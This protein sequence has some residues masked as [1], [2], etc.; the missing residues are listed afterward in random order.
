MSNPA[1]TKRPADDVHPM[2][3]AAERDHDALARIEA[4]QARIE[5]K[6]DRLL[7]G[8]RP[9][10]LSR[11]DRG[12]CELIA[13][14]EPMLRAAAIVVRA[15]GSTLTCLDKT[16]QV[17]FVQTRPEA[18]FIL[19]TAATLKGLYAELGLS[20]SGRCRVSL[21]PASKLDAFLHERHGA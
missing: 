3:V 10:S 13:R 15:Q 2:S 12:V 9:S 17:K 16:G 19:K 11:A 8:T 14:L 1:L 7:E 18:T 5:M 21:S 6:L 20:P 4:N